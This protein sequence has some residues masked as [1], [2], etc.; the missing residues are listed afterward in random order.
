MLLDVLEGLVEFTWR[1]VLVEVDVLDCGA[2]VFGDAGNGLTKSLLEELRA[3]LGSG[4]D[5]FLEAGR[6]V[7]LH[8]LVHA[9]LSQFVH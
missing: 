9:E 5:T 8:P 2:T 3:V 4:S 7:P 6:W 1:I